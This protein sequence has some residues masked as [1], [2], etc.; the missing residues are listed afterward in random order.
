MSPIASTHVSFTDK[1]KTI[2]L[3]RVSSYVMPCELYLV[4]SVHLC[5]YYS[6]NV[7][8]D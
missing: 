7:M 3:A 8:L 6:P 2:Y 5:V 4:T 1:L